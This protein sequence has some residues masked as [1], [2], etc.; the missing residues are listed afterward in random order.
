MVIKDTWQEIAMKNKLKNLREDS[1]LAITVE[2][3]DI[4]QG[5]ALRN[6]L[7]NLRE[8]NKLAISAASLDILPEIALNK[9]EEWGE[10]IAFI[11]FKILI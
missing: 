1:K 3:L 4:L 5:I 7:K 6:K 8:N 10:R 11:L 9:N 2:K